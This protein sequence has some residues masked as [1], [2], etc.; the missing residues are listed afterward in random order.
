MPIDVD[1]LHEVAR[2]LLIKFS[3]T[4]ALLK[5]YVKGQLWCVRKGYF[6]YQ[7]TEPVT[8]A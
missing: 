3:T 2:I 5:Y 8:G 6:G 7:F 4:V 1:Y